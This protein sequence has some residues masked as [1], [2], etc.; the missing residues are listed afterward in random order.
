MEEMEKAFFQ[1][2]F[3]QVRDRPKLL[4]GLLLILELAFFGSGTARPIL[5]RLIS[6]VSLA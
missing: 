5:Q 2:R 6:V 1:P 3:K 4:A